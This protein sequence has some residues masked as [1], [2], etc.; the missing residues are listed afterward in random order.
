MAQAVMTS[1]HG[2]PRLTWPTGLKVNTITWYI[3]TWDENSTCFLYRDGSSCEGVT[4]TRRLLFWMFH[5]DK[6]APLVKVSP[7]QDGSSCEGFTLT[8]QFLLWMFHLDKTAPLVNVS[9][10][11][12]SSSCE[13]FT[14]TRR[15]LLW[16]FHLDKTAPSTDVRG[17]VWTR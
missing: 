2:H 13:C 5:L 10:W 15:L 6:T 12:D 9:P 1:T 17:L 3:V 16:M 4:L 7:W 11:Q 14:L 8:R